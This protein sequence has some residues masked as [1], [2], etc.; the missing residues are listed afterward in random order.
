M[1]ISLKQ[2][3]HFDNKTSKEYG[4]LCHYSNGPQISASSR[5]LYITATYNALKRWGRGRMNGI[6]YKNKLEQKWCSVFYILYHK[7]LNFGIQLSQ[8]C[9]IHL[10]SSPQSATAMQ[11]PECALQVKAPAGEVATQ[12]CEDMAIPQECAQGSQQPPAVLELLLP[13]AI[14][15]LVWKHWGGQRDA[16]EKLTQP[17]LAQYKQ[18]LVPCLVFV[19]VPMLAAQPCC[20]RGQDVTNCFRALL[21]SGVLLDLCEGKHFSLDFCMATSVAASF[22][23]QVKIFLNLTMESISVMKVE[24]NPE[25]KE[26]HAREYRLLGSS[27]ER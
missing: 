7:V 8:T 12:P 24:E 1:K 6:C 26:G 9:I 2:G 19:P 13:Q 15:C 11:S 17:C 5:R 4:G 23:Q 14:S 18:N 21:S 27:A 22:S 16:E 3:S 25:Q 10:L 20:R